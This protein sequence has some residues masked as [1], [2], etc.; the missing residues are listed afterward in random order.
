M[1]DNGN[2]PVASKPDKLLRTYNRSKCIIC[3]E[4]KYLADR[5]SRE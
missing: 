4:D 2:V 5:K 1:D 3:L